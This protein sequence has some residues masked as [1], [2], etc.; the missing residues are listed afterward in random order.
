MDALKTHLLSLLIILPL[1]VSSCNAADKQSA[2]PE[3]TI[4]PEDFHADN[5]IA[6]TVQSI[7]DAIRIG[8]NLD[9]ADYNF[10]GILTDG[11]G[12]P[13]YTNVQGMPGIWD[14]EVLSKS[15]IVLRNRDIGDLLPED[16]ELYLMSALDLT[17]ENLLSEEESVMDDDD[18]ASRIV[19]DFEG[20]YLRIDS[21]AATASNG[22]EGPLITIT[23][24][25]KRPAL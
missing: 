7:A 21:R 3:D 19:Y 17:G 2:T 8:E 5:D 16:L 11:Q 15:S 13:L 10:H 24:S 4:A 23:L 22:L 6:M 20:G 18:E 12:I 25:R 9:S 1:L 14:V